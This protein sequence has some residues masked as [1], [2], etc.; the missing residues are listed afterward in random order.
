MTS[1]IQVSGSGIQVFGYASVLYYLLFVLSVCIVSVCL[2]WSNVL[3]PSYCLGLKFTYFD[4]FL[5]SGLRGPIRLDFG[6]EADPSPGLFGFCGY[7][8]FSCLF[9][10]TWVRLRPRIVLLPHGD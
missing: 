5:R 6:S 9:L 4:S 1:G 7:S 10:L 8:L 3:L 2:D